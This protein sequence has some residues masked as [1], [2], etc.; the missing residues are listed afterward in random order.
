MGL[1]ADAVSQHVGKRGAG[2]PATL[3]SDSQAQ[4]Q[5]LV[6]RSLPPKLLTHTHTHTC[7]GSNYSAAYMD[8]SVCP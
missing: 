1:N 2:N 3:G 8:Y 6:L 4:V 5:L 7:Y